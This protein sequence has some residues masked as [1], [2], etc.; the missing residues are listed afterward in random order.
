MK[1]QKPVIY[2]VEVGQILP[3]A[4]SPGGVTIPGGGNASGGGD[5]G[6]GGTPPPMQSPRNYWGA[7]SRPMTT[8]RQRTKT[9]GKRCPA[10]SGYSLPTPPGND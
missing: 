10:P 6:G 1:Y 5:G 9:I 8:T 7:A 2:S 3:I 4:A